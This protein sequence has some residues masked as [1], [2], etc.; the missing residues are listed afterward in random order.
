[1]RTMA[2]KSNLVERIGNRV[3]GYEWGP[4]AGQ[5]SGVNRVLVVVYT[6]AVRLCFWDTQLAQGIMGYGK[7]FQYVYADRI[8]D[9]KAIQMSYWEL[10]LG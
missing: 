8:L 7:Y 1:M 2:N 6:V 10:M 9:I 5:H 3:D 4:A